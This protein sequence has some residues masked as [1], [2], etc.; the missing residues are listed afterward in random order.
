MGKGGNGNSSKVASKEQLDSTWAGADVVEVL[1]SSSST[2]APLVETFSAGWSEWL[3]LV[4]II[5]NLSPSQTLA[6]FL[7]PSLGV[8]WMELGPLLPLI[9]TPII[10]LLSFS[11]L[12]YPALPPATIPF[13]SHR[14]S[15]IDSE[16]NLPEKK[17]GLGTSLSPSLPAGTA[18][19]YLF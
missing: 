2:L 9:I 18:P 19:I 1:W 8:L 14:T 13:I 6:L 16:Q 17:K 10:I 7:T 15:G 11:S 12:S 3:L 5:L 4:G